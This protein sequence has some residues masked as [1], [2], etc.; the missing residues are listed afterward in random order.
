MWC[1][2]AFLIVVFPQN[3]FM[4]E[5]A[6]LTAKI[7]QA[8]L[9]DDIAALRSSRASLLRA[10]TNSATPA[11]SIPLLRYSLAYTDWRMVFA[12]P[13]PESERDGLLDEAESQLQLALKENDKFA[14]AYAL[15]AGVY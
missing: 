10:L 14:E 2:I 9:N 11:N 8:Y 7:D 15:L 12:P 5:F 1:L 3:D 4:A 13:V 6:A